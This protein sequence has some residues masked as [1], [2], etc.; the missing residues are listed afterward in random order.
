MNFGFELEFD[1][2]EI[3]KKDLFTI[4]DSVI[5]KHDS[6]HKVADG[7]NVGDSPA[8]W[9]VKEDT[10]CGWEVTSPV[11]DSSPQSFRTLKKILKCFEDYI[12]PDATKR[13]CGLHVHF[14]VAHFT[15]KQIQTA[16]SIFKAME[17]A[18][19]KL[20]PGRTRSEYV[21]KIGG[22]NVNEI[23]VGDDEDCPVFSR[24]KAVNINRFHQ[25]GTME[26]RYAKGTTN[27]E[28]ILRWIQ[29]LACIL[30]IA[31]HNEVK[32]TKAKTVQPLCTLLSKYSTK[33][34]FLESRKTKIIEWMHK[35]SRNPNKKDTSYSVHKLYKILG[36]KLGRWPKNCNAPCFLNCDSCRW[37]AKS[38][39]TEWD[40]E[41]GA[42]HIRTAA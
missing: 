4:V 29:L 24:Y 30:E 31:R 10:S 36:K 16:F 13:K 19:L 34:A 23:D 3:S 28:D 41:N 12:D 39:F 11:F 37:G 6:G 27:A 25:R 42:Q 26:I 17:P 22:I 1:D 2:N 21:N 7:D 35:K 15:N 40:F 5:E 9:T 18:V 14:C 8:E 33:D 20:W 32:V 38:M